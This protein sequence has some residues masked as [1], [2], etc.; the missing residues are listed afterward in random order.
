MLITPWKRLMYSTLHHHDKLYPLFE[1]VLGAGRVLLQVTATAIGRSRLPPLLYISSPE[2][3]RY[4][5]SPLHVVS[6]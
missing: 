3:A 5:L 4:Y 1:G 6:E 2:M